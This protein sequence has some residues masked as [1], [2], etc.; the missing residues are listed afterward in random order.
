V[1]GEVAAV[2]LAAATAGA[3]AAWAAAQ[4][5]PDLIRFAMG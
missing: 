5:A 2:L 4:A 1:L 3:I